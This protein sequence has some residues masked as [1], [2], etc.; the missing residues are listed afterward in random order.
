MCSEHVVRKIMAILGL[1]CVP[2][3]KADSIDGCYLASENIANLSS[4]EQEVRSS[5]VSVSRAASGYSVEGIIWGANLHVCHIAS[6]IEGGD[7]PLR[8]DYVDNGLI[9]NHDE[10]EY[11]ISCEL[12]LSF[13]NDVLTITDYN[14][15]CSRYVF[16]CGARVGLDRVELPKVEQACP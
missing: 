7:G 16:Y 6:P 14:H 1:L 4:E 3:V 11:N 8:M 13:E 10:A 9:Y 2:Y 5:Y 15:H 12:E